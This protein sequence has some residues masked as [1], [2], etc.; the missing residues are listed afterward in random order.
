[1]QFDD[2]TAH[3]AGQIRQFHA[4]IVIVSMKTINE[5]LNHQSNRQ[6]RF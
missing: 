2:Y 1:M 6:P 3:M 5:V 4:F